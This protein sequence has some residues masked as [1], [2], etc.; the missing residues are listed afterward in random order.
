MYENLWFNMSRFF[1][2]LERY[3]TMQKLPIKYPSSAWDNKILL[4]VA[5]NQPKSYQ[6][7]DCFQLNKKKCKKIMDLNL[8]F[9]L[10]KDP[11]KNKIWV[12]MDGLFFLNDSHFH[13]FNILSL[14]CVIPRKER[15]NSSNSELWVWEVN[16]SL[17]ISRFLACLRAGVYVCMCVR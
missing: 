10:R 7:C 17:S 15:E 13:C 3:T 1:S 2:I 5:E 16:L 9:K 6:L 4:A 14:E 8:K 12:Y 11:E